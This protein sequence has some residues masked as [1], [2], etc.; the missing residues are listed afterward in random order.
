MNI[1]RFKGFPGGTVVKNP[2]SAGDA[3]WEDLLEKEMA[4]R[5]SIL[6]WEIPR[7]EEPGGLQRMESQK[8]RTW[9]SN[10]TTATATTHSGEM[11]VCVCVHCMY[12][13]EAKRYYKIMGLWKN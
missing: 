8:S 2:A 6:A 3:G 4:A 13:R 11:C 9:L 12:G 10:E 5:S 1:K 7:T